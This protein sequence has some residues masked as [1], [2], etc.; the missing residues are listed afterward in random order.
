MIV[1]EPNFVDFGEF[2]T[3]QSP[4]VRTVSLKNTGARSALFAID[5]GNNELDLLVEPKKGVV[6]VSKVKC[7]RQQ[8]CN[9]FC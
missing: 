8:G 3:W 5:L 4:E 9:F 7:T 2:A 1:V 6:S